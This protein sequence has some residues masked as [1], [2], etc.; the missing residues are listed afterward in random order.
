[1]LN[2]RERAGNFLSASQ[3]VIQMAAQAA[4]MGKPFEVSFE[5]IAEEAYKLGGIQNASRFIGGTQ[6]GAG[7][8]EAGPGVPGDVDGAAE[9]IIA[10]LQ[11]EAAFG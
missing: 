4:Q 6:G 10:Q 11:P 9:D 5:E 1:M 8:P 3:F 7:Q 2:E